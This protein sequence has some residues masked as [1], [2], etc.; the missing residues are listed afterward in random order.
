[1]TDKFFKKI[2]AHVYVLMTFDH[3]C[4]VSK[5][6]KSKTKHKKEIFICFVFL[7]KSP[8]FVPFPCLK[9]LKSPVD[10]DAIFLRIWQRRLGMGGRFKHI[11]QE[12]THVDAKLEFFLK[13]ENN[14]VCSPRQYSFI[15]KTIISATNRPHFCVF[16]YTIIF[17]NLFLCL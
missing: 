11:S 5:G 9:R 2:R 1:M 7:Y 4:R 12:W 17:I 10:P 3:Q 13:K 16:S 8:A 14:P 15:R 6:H